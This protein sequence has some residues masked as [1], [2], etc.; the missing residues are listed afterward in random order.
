MHLLFSW[1][2]LE[3][4]DLRIRIIR[5]LSFDDGKTKEKLIVYRF[6]SEK[7]QMNE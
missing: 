7:K 1:L 5:S 6:I 2:R 4:K 3:S